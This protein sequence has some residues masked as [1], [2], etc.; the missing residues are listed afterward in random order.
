LVFVADTGAIAAV[1][2]VIAEYSSALYFIFTGFH[3]PKVL[4]VVIALASIWLLTLVNLFG[5]FLSGIV[6]TVFSSIKILAVGAIIGIAFTA[7]GNMANFVNPL[8]PESFSW[9]T[10]LAVGAALRY[11]FF[12]FSGWEG[13]TY[14]AEEVKNPRRNLPLSLLFGI[15]GVLFLY[16]GANSAYIYLLPAEVISN[17][18]WV[19]TEAMQVAIG[20]T[21]GILI[22]AAVMMNTFGNVS[23]QILVKARS[24]QAM[25]RDGVFFRAMA[26]I[27]PRY[28][29]P[30]KALLIQAAWATVLMLFAANARS[31]YEVIIDFF[32]ATGTIFNIMT[33][34][35]VVVL[36]RKY[37]DLERPYRAWLYPFSVIVVIAIYAAFLVLTLITRLHPSHSWDFC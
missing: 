18:K 4:V 15:V 36:R 32:S 9:S 27:H 13:A 26:D 19:A 29:T 5:V 14:I 21:G 11:S 1:A 17:S 23:T 28:K 2:L 37:R 10:V 7:K 20:S 24:W 8:W 31:S 3:F 12:A 30:N 35:S 16:V 25:A 34:A 33:L 22:S 6:Q